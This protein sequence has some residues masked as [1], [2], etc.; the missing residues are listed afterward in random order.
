[1]DVARPRLIRRPRTTAAERERGR[2][3]RPKGAASL[4]RNKDLLKWHSSV[5]PPKL[6]ARYPPPNTQTRQLGRSF[7]DLVRRGQ[8]A[9]AVAQRIAVRT[10]CAA[11]E[12]RRRAAASPIPA[13][14]SVRLV[15]VTG[16]L[17]RLSWVRRLARC[18]RGR[19]WAWGRWV[20]CWTGRSCWV[21]WWWATSY[22]SEQCS[23]KGCQT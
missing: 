22:W 23:A 6:A 13:R 21:T 2:P 4:P 16:L 20:S 3:T 1:M 8:P 15:M 10:R 11:L 5:P 7:T 17:V 18:W 14:R 19:S 9:R 12:A